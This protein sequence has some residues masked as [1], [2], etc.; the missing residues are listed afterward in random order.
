MFDILALI[1]LLVMPYAAGVEGG[2]G[3]A[4]QQLCYTQACVSYTDGNNSATG[5]FC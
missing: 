3:T 1:Q 2:G 5:G 4:L